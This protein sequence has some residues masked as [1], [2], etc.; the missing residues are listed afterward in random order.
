MK[1]MFEYKDVVARLQV[2]YD[3]SAEDRDQREKAPWKL[4][5]RA[6]F[7]SI[8]RTEG[9]V[10]LLEIGA[11]TGQDGLFFQKGGLETVVTDLSPEMVAR[12]RAK[13]LVAYSADFLNLGFPLSSFDAVYAMNCLL[14]VPNVNLSDVLAA[15][16]NVL[17]PG[18]LFFLGVYGGDPFEG[19]APNDWHEP[20]RFFSI[21]TDDQMHGYVR[22]YF[23]VLDFHV[24]E[25][26]GVHFQSVTLR[27]PMLTK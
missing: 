17:V 5:E 24:V 2:A 8:V 4:T 22:E 11:G 19:E 21:R 12:C 23:D 6:D 16:R 13:G 9:K 25:P 26:E 14:H 18:G 3:G 1:A 20:P 7:L 27:K 10:S 15:I